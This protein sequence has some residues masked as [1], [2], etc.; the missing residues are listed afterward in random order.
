MIASFEGENCGFPLLLKAVIDEE[1]FDD[2]I[3]CMQELDSRNK[4]DID[5]HSG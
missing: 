2:P 1:K 3:P 4:E 5:T